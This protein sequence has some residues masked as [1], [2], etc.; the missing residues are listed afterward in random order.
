MWLSQFKKQNT[1]I[2]PTSWIGNGANPIVV[3]TGEANDPHHYYFGGKGGRATVNHGNMDGGSFIFELNG[4][5][6][7]VD[8]GNQNYHTLEKNGFNLWERCQEC[9][10]WTLLTKN[11]FGHSTFTVNNQFHVV[12]GKATIKDFKAGINPEATI[13]MSPT[14]EGQLKSVSRTFLKDSPISLV[15]TD[16]IEISEETKLITWQLMTT[17]DVKIIKGGAKL[18]KDGKTL[19]LENISHPELTLSIVSLYPAPL[20]LDRQILGL[21]RLEIRIPSWTI[22]E[23]KCEIKIRLSGD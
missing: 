1:E 22:K 9:E 17:A 6:W 3:F 21:K 5:R 14:F 13:E 7:V 8:P 18:I 19:I 16:Q 12:D 2:V 15:I 4:V 10:R 11:N 20:E 23:G